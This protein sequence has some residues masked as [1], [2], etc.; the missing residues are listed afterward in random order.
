MSSGLRRPRLAGYPEPT[1]SDG[2]AASLPQQRRKNRKAD[3][4]HRVR[5]GGGLGAGDVR[6]LDDPARDLMPRAA[7]DL[8]TCETPPEHWTPGAFTLVA[9][10]GFEPATSGL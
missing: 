1:L 9:G 2:D 5:E 8:A 6:H 10:A 3:A 7:R 4:K